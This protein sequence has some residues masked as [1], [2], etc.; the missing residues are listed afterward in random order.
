MIK[1]TPSLK[2][3]NYGFGAGRVPFIYFFRMLHWL[4]IVKDEPVLW[5]SYQRL[6]EKI[7]YIDKYC[8]RLEEIEREW[9]RIEQE[10]EQKFGCRSDGSERG[11]SST[12]LSNKL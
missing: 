6:Q 4:R 5:D 9:L 7:A 10:F 12:H 8:K 2:L 11:D 3:P 1:P